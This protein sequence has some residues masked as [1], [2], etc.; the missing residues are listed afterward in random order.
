MGTEIEFFK[1]AGDSSNDYIEEVIYFS[2]KNAREEIQGKQKKLVAGRGL[3]ISGNMIS[4][5]D[6]IGGGG[7]NVKYVTIDN[8]LGDG[9]SD[10]QETEVIDNNTYGKYAV[11]FAYIGN[12]K[13]FLDCADAMETNESAD[14]YSDMT[15]LNFVSEIAYNSTNRQRAKAAIAE[16]DETK[17]DY[18]LL[19][20]VRVSSG[21]FLRNINGIASDYDKL[22][23]GYFADWYYD[24]YGERIQREAITSS[25][26][27]SDII[28]AIWRYFAG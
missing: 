26:Y 22:E 20:A 6:D 9:Y 16:L 1:R 18:F 2:D 12:P 21:S 28:P 17:D 7:A 8:L 24:S 14:E 4:L 5:A 23:G 19:L 25:N 27:K 3:K 11:Q 13:I 10:G 15:A